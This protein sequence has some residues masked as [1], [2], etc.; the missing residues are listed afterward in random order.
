MIETI[1]S[2]VGEENINYLLL[3][4]FGWGR[5]GLEI[6]KLAAS[7]PNC[8]ALIFISQFPI[9]LEQEFS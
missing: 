9:P 2:L 6:H 3:N 7:C 8:L 5:S 4:V 1:Y